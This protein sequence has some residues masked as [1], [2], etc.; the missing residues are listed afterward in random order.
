M[1]SPDFEQQSEHIPGVIAFA[2]E[3]FL[4]FPSLV[5]VNP[6]A[7]TSFGVGRQA[8]PA[9]AHGPAEVPVPVPL[10]MPTMPPPLAPGTKPA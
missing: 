9:L 2:P 7:Q 1:P 5:G 6:L 4:L 3:I 10:P 8:V